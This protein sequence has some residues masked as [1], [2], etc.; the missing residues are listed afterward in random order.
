V[1]RQEQAL[2]K[3]Q[4]DRDKLHYQDALE[5]Y[6]LK[7]KTWLSNQAK[8]GDD[9]APQRPEKPREKRLMTNDFTNEALAEILAD[10]PRGMLLFLDEIMSAAST[11][12]DPI[13]ARTDPSHWKATTAGRVT[14]IARDQR[15]TESTSRTGRFRWSAA[16]S[17]AS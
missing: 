13:K 4:Y 1:I 12:I 11:P 14:L 3:R 2:M 15:M 16:S 17:T 9:E 8:G 6:Q 10:N 5:L 7:R